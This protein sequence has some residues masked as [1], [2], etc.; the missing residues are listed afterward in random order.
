MT[1]PRERQ[2]GFTLLELLIALAI[3]AILAAIAY[4]AY[5]GYVQEAR[6]ADG[7]AGLLETAQRLERCY[8]RQ[9]S[10]QGCDGVAFPQLS[11]DGHYSIRVG[12]KDGGYLTA[13]TYRLVAVPQ[14]AQADDSCG[15]LT[16][17]QAGERD[18]TGSGDE[19]W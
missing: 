12:D 16:L 17:T 4:P 10:Y 3:I 15:N 6:R 14:G 9:S 11:P 5:T 7:K 18:A 19:C 1:K 2:A 13:T 8:T